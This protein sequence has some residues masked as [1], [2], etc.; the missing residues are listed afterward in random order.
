[1]R[2]L[3]S[4]EL[5]R[6]VRVTKT[7]D[8]HFFMEWRLS[9][10]DSSNPDP[11]SDYKIILSH[12]ESPESEFIAIKD[13]AGLDIEFNCDTSTSFM[14]LED[15]YDFNRQFYIKFDLYQISSGT[16]VD[17]KTTHCYGQADGIANVVAFNEGLLYRSWT[18][19]QTK[20]WRI[21][22]EGARCPECW[23]EFTQSSNKSYCGTCDGSGFVSG[24]FNPITTQ[25]A[26]EYGNKSQQTTQV[27]IE[28][29][30]QMQ[31]RL[32]NYPMVRPGDLIM[33]CDTAQRFIVEKIQL[34]QLPNIRRKKEQLSG[35]TFIVSQILVLQELTATDPEYKKF[36]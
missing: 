9:Q 33:N 11:L 5:G 8:N 12:S 17:S 34:T 20:I 7:S 14:W 26:F 6:Y 31:A 32:S 15:I 35:G 36:I 19:Y 16:K 24:H 25:V 1:M 4:S 22:A 10:S 21:K 3:D 30:Q 27:S 23:N 18:G 29:K 2:F 28:T 13:D